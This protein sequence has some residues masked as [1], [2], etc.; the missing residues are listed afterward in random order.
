MTKDRPFKKVMLPVMLAFC[1]APAFG[2]EHLDCMNAPMG[3]TEQIVLKRHHDTVRGND[4]LLRAVQTSLEAR[5]RV[6]GYLNGW[7]P[8]ATRLA[9]EYVWLQA[10]WRRIPSGFS[11]PEE[12]RLETAL[13]PMQ[14]RLKALMAPSANAVARGEEPPPP[15]YGSSMFKEFY[16]LLKA[17]K[18][19][20][21]SSS[22]GTLS[23]WLYGKGFQAAVVD[24]FSKE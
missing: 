10:Q 11:A 23:G 17:S 13:Q 6:C 22:E 5:A 4:E 20:Q 16:V 2:A 15:P 14:F 7:S 1:S 3:E 12:E 21:N 24:A 8:N 9:F 18:I 19:P